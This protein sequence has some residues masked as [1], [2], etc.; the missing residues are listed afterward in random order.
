MR[1][2]EAIASIVVKAPMRNSAVGAP[3]NPAR[4]GSAVIS[5]SGPCERPLRRRSERSVPAA[6]NSA[7]CEMVMACGR[8][9]AAP[10]F[11][12]AIRR[13]GRIGNF[14]RPDA[15]RVADRIGERGRGRHRR[16]L[17]DADAAAE[18][19]V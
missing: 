12:A 16:D 4:V 8:H 3:I 1:A 11:S 13:S 18:H 7:V 5:I 17:A 2:S 15:G 19:M 14:G 9:A 10:F 6:R